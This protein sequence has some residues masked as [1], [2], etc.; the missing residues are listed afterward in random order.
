MLRWAHWGVPGQMWSCPWKMKRSQGFPGTEKR[1]VR[2]QG[3]G[4]HLQSEKRREEGLWSLANNPPS[5]QSWRRQMS[6]FSHWSV[7]FAVVAPANQ[8]IQMTGFDTETSSSPNWFI[9]LVQTL[10]KSQMVLVEADDQMPNYLLKIQ[11][12][13]LQIGLSVGLKVL[14]FSIYHKAIVI[15]MLQ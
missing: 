13:L 4:G 6:S 9:D 11:S 15:K 8:Q 1:Q 10:W 7:Y 3:A 2:T 12:G 5:R 14:K